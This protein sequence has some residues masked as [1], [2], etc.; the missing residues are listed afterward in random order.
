MLSNKYFIFLTIQLKQLDCAT[1]W[2]KIMPCGNLQLP[3]NHLGL[4]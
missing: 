1:W 4:I 2:L 3:Y